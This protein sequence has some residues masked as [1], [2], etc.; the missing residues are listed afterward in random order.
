MLGVVVM[1]GGEWLHPSAL[2]YKS[3]N[4]RWIRMFGK[5]KGGVDIF[6]DFMN[7]GTWIEDSMTIFYQKFMVDRALGELATK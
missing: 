5:A 2:K 4:D 1:R 3:N 7:K 6:E